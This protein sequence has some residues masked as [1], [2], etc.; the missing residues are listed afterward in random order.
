MPSSSARRISASS[1][2]TRPR[3]TGSTPISSRAASRAVRLES[4]IWPGPSGRP[5]AT[6][7]S[8]VDRTPTRGRVPTCTPVAPMLANTPRWAGVRA[9]PAPNTSSPACR[10]SP[11]RR[12]WLPG[13]TAISTR[14]PSS[15]TA[16]VRSTITTA[17]APGG[18]GAP[19]MIRTASP[20]PTARV[21]ATPAGSVSTT[22]RSTGAPTVSIERTANPSMAVLSNGG[23][24]SGALIGSRSTRPSASPTGTTAVGV[25]A[26]RSRTYE[27]A[28]AREIIG[29]SLGT[30]AARGAGGSLLGTPSTRQT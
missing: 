26:H 23:T 21:G 15:P 17:S 22:A 25:G 28:S 29:P 12:T 13:S 6:S 20:A 4:R 9:V 1:S 30:A 27:R 7:S 16:A 8:P 3:S 5:G 24:A 19:V 10:S 2:A 14:T 11:A 18:I